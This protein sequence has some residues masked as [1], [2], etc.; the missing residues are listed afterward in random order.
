MSRKRLLVAFS[1]LFAL[2]VPLHAENK[3]APDC[4]ATAAKV[5]A[6]LQKVA[7][8]RNLRPTDDEHFIR[9]AYLD[10]A[11]RLPRPETVRAF[12]ADTSADKRTHVIDR[13]LKTREYAVNWG[14]YWRDVVSYN[15]LASGNYLCWNKYDTW[16]TDQLDQNI[17]WDKVVTKLITASGPADEVPPVNYLTGLFANPREAAAVTSRVFLGIQIQCAECHNAKKDMGI[18]W[19]REQF[20]E[21]AAFF[22]RIKLYQCKDRKS[23]PRYFAVDPEDFGQYKMTRKDDP[24]R[25]IDMQPRFLT[26]ESV[27]MNATDTERREALAKLVTSSKNPW[28]ARA[29]VNRMWSSLMGWGF[30]QRVDSLG[31]NETPHYPELLDMLSQEWIASGYDVKWLFR[32]IMLTRAYQSQ[33]LPAPG[34]EDNPCATG[35][36]VRLRPE[37]VYEAMQSALG[38]SEKDE[39][40]PAPAIKSAPALQRH[41]GTRNMVYMTFK[42]D[43]SLPQSEISSTIPQ[44]LLMMNSELVHR[45][46]SAKPKTLLGQLLA[47][48]RTDQQILNAMFGRVLARRPTVREVDICNRYIAKVNHREEALEDILWGLVNSTEFLIKK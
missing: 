19:K 45:Y 33:L 3:K 20:H 11:G 1:L 4:L 8:P 18:A 47:E 9:R 30:Y 14:R 7:K 2:C 34:A 32:T 29:Y 39:S 31:S 12:V 21:F 5:D 46:T 44:A 13:L 43:P 40:I 35:C 41:K 27:S 10:L 38:F 26:G 15:S 6:A 17:N 42:E 23:G 16:W 48:G 37:Q 36:P 22:G 28:F 25:T 24:A